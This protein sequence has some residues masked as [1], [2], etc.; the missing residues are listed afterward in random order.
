[1]FYSRV[2]S[3]PHLTKQY[4]TEAWAVRGVVHC[5]PERRKGTATTKPGPLA[6]MKVTEPNYEA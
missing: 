1:M 3:I 5:R 4:G 2:Q 6:A